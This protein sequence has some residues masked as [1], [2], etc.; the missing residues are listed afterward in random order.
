MA[1]GALGTSVGLSANEWTTDDGQKR[2]SYKLSVS[3]G[4]TTEE[5]G[6]AESDWDALSKDDRARLAMFGQP[7]AVKVRVGAF[8]DN[9]GGAKLSLRMLDI[10]FLTMA[11]LRARGFEVVFYTEDDDEELSSS[12]AS[13]GATP[14]S[15]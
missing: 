14:A 7:L 12:F 2:M 3:T 10:E 15:A 6:I 13:N 9:R 8:G 11:Q 1:L 4:D 5:I